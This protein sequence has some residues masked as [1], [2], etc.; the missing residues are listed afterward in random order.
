MGLLWHRD[1]QQQWQDFLCHPWEPAPGHRRVPCQDGGQVRS[2][3]VPGLSWQE[4]QRR[5]LM[6]VEYG[7]SLRD[8]SAC[9]LGSEPGLPATRTKLFVVYSCKKMIHVLF[10]L[11][12]HQQLTN[13]APIAGAGLLHHGCM[14][15]SS[16]AKLHNW[17]YFKDHKLV[18]E[19]QNFVLVII[20]SLGAPAQLQLLVLSSGRGRREASS[21]W[22]TQQWFSGGVFLSHLTPGLQSATSIPTL[23]QRPSCSAH[24]CSKWAWHRC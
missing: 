8:S 6:T 22:W 23:T 11:L 18:L 5:N 10:W 3:G 13:G 9:W 17:V 21:Q 24:H 12:H 19:R 15:L 2:L 1:Q 20:H 4:E 16:S 14:A 7:R